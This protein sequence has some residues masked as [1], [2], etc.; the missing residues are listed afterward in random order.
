MKQIYL[1]A[2]A[3]LFTAAS[4]AQS[5]SKVY[6]GFI[7]HFTKSVQWPSSSQNGDFVIGV[8]GASEMESDL[9]ALAASK[10]VGSRKIIIKKYGSA[11]E[12]GECDILF[13][14]KGNTAQ[15]SKVAATAKLNSTL[16]VTESEGAATQGAVI[17]FTSQNG[18]VRFE[19]N[20]NKAKDHGLKVSSDLQRLAILVP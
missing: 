1:I 10:K 2:L 5:T 7:Y 17:N 19:L 8:L 16:I 3:L 4:H 20:M 9:D 6:S 13:I 12:V 11:S 15:L 18:K 14:G